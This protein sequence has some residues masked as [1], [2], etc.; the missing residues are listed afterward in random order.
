VEAAQSVI[1]H[2]QTFSGHPLQARTLLRAVGET[3]VVDP[4]F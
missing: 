4:E 2:W 3:K 1:R